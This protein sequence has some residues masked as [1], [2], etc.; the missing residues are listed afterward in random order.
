[1]TG[2]TAKDVINV[3]RGW[4]GASS[5]NTII[6]IYNAH[7]PLAQGYRMKYTDAWCDATVSA[8]FI[9]LDAVDL[10]GGTECG[11]ERHI[12]LFK[13]AGIWEEDGT[14]IPE[15]GWII[16]FNWDESKQ[17][18]NGFA[19]HIG[20]VESVV[21]NTVNTIEGNSY[22]KVARCSY[23]VG[24][25]NIRGYAK[26]KYVAV[27]PEDKKYLLAADV[28]EFQGEID[29]A[30]FSKAVDLVIIRAYNGSRAD[31]YWTRN[32]AMA[33]KYKVPY[34]VYMFSQATTK[35]QSRKENTALIKLLEGHSPNYP[36]F[37]D[38]ENTRFNYGPTARIVAEQF[39]DDMFAAGY[40]PGLY[41]G[42]YFYDQ[43]LAG[44][45]TESLWLASYGT[46]DGT[47]QEG[48]RP[49]YDLDGWQYTS[50]AKVAG[51]TA[52]TV[53]LSRFYKEYDTSAIRI[54]Y[55]PHCQ[56]YGWKE[57]SFNG[58]WAGTTGEGKRLEALRIDPPEGVELEVTVHLQGIGDKV[59]SGIRHGNNMV[60][61]TV[62]ESR[63]MEGISMRCTKN[64]TG[65]KLYY[66]VHS[67]TFGDMPACGEGE[68]AGTR[69]QS[70][71]MEAIRIGFV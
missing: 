69:G 33:E 41:T 2:I 13:R 28:S 1:M 58:E 17:P 35:E 14:V 52:N 7:K 46:N 12:Q 71:R 66:Q 21:G 3:M 19:D 34:G 47:A 25:G 37:L 29:W 16:C 63:R 59:Y 10:I 56:S 31:K 42:W 65:R 61:G 50:V 64:L 36:V 54:R 68:F 27:Q 6:D 15:P 24:Y 51:I 44:V 18:N 53:D 60:I 9:K 32:V 45:K 22:G 8:A 49:P 11:V 67:Q 39:Y 23:A 30:Q 57:P 4:L 5:H 40:I 70:K 20:I 26:P 43:Y 62:G 38:K 48:R 55:Q